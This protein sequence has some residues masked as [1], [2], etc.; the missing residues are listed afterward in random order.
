M[1]ALSRFQTMAPNSKIITEELALAFNRRFGRPAFPVK[2]AKFGRGV[3]FAFD[4]NISF[5]LVAEWTLHHQERIRG[6]GNCD[7]ELR[8]G[9]ALTDWLAAMA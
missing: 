5:R 4:E 9:P 7:A 8:H 3:G 1:A 2:V 6:F